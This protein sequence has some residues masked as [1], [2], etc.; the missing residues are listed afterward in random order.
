MDTTDVLITGRGDINLDSEALNLALR[1]D[2]KKLR[3]TRLRTPITIKGTLDHPSVGIDAGK[4]AEQG[5]VATAMGTLLTPVAAV[6]AFID[7]GLAKNKD[8]TASLAEAGR[9]ANP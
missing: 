9:P 2:P 8:C 1:G 6:L 3:L 5:A 4:L 7:P